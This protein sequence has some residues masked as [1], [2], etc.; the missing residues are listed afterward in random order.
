MHAYLNRG[1]P[2][3]QAQQDFDD[4]PSHRPAAS[5]PR[6]AAATE[7][8]PAAAGRKEVAGKKDS[9]GGWF[10]RVKVALGAKSEAE[11]RREGLEVG[12]RPS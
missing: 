4:D 2:T 7:A 10:G 8:A 3:H 1:A 6:V 5:A 9:G 12:P 11:K